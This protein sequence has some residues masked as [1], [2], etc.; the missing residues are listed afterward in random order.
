M[1]KGIKVNNLGNRSTNGEDYTDELVQFKFHLIAPAVY[2]THGMKSNKDYFRT[3]SEKTLCAPDGSIRHYSVPTLQRWHRDFLKCNM[4]SLKTKTRSDKGGTRKL[5]PSAQVRLSELVQDVPTAKST[6]LY[7]RLRKEHLI[8]DGTA[9]CDTVRRYINKNKLREGKE[10]AEKLRNSFLLPHSGDLYISD[11]CYYEKINPDSPGNKRPWVYVQGIVDDHSRLA[12]VEECTLTD[13]AEVFQRTLRKC[14]SLYGVPRMLYTDL[15]SPY[16]NKDL[17]KICNRLGVALVHAHPHDGAAKGVVERSWGSLEMDTQVDIVIDKLNTFEQIAERVAEWKDEYNSR[18]NTGVK[19]V[20]AE[21]WAASVGK[22]PLRRLSEKDLS[23]AFSLVRTRQLSNTGILSLNNVKYKAPDKLRNVVRPRTS[24]NIVYDPLD[25]PGTIHVEY[26][27]EN[28]PLT[29]D[30]PYE[31]ARVNAA[32]AREAREQR[33]SIVGASAADIRAEE[34]YRQR[35]AGTNRVS[36][37]KTDEVD[38]DTRDSS[39]PGRARCSI[40]VVDEAPAEKLI[41]MEII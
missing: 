26:D 39:Q 41:E 18:V 21:R 14:I 16:N 31:N 38:E 33:K 37:K 5:S 6:T 13:S 30:D 35:M 2:G 40:P 12:M 29:V 28:Y 3:V 8:E 11:T 7:K 4:D 9:C 23:E 17:T 24:L 27:G 32:R 22:H 15:G 20:P 36:G 1:A 19:G 34:R 25:I 10:T